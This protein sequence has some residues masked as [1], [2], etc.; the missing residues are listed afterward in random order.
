MTPNPPETTIGV[1]AVQDLHT[2]RSWAQAEGWNP[3]RGDLLPFFAADPRGFLI[4]RRPDDPTPVSGI[5]VVRYGTDHAFLGLYLA[6]PDVRGQGYGIQVW[7]AGMARVA[8]RT[9]GLD[10]VVAQQANYRKSGFASAWTN[11]RYEGT[12]NTDPVPAPPGVVLTDATALPFALLAA[13]DRRFFPTARDTFLAAWLTAPHRASLAAVQDGRV[14]GLAVRRACV[15]GSRIGPCYADTPAVAASLLTH[16]ATETPI[17][18]DVPDTN[19][20]AVHLAEQLALTP[21]FETSRM[22]TA[23]PPRLDH[24]ALYGI[25]TLELG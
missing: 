3:G 11:T 10:G 25:S 5:S 12:L 1:A 23:A 8:G 20:A 15:T 7:N 16:L 2:T 24:P 17:A 22:Y 6:R 21:T 14:V 4:A 18:L 9:V 13:Y 19:P